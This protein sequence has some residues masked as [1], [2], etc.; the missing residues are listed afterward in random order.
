MMWQDSHKGYRFM[1]GSCC[2]RCGAA[3][4]T[5]QNDS[6]NVVYVETK[7][8]QS[9]FGRCPKQELPGWVEEA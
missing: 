5:Y 7:S 4:M 9:H 6:G 1:Y 2:L 3:L 8:Q